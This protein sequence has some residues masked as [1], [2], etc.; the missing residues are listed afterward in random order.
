M[1]ETNNEYTL[2][3]GNNGTY[4]GT[5]YPTLEEC[6]E[7]ARYFEPFGELKPYIEQDEEIVV[8]KKNFQKMYDEYFSNK[9]VSNVIEQSEPIEESV[10][11]GEPTTTFEDI[12][13]ANEE[14]SFNEVPTTESEKDELILESL[15]VQEV[16]ESGWFL[17]DGW[18]ASHPDKVLGIPYEST[19]RYGK[20]TKYK[21]TIEDIDRIDVIVPTLSKT[22]DNSPLQ[23]GESESF[24]QS[25]SITN[26]ENQT[27]ILDEIDESNKNV[28][29]KFANKKEKS[30]NVEDDSLVFNEPELQTFEDVWRTYNQGI[31]K[32][33]LEVYIWH[34]T[35]IG[36][37]L[38][39]RWINL[40]HNKLYD[41]DLT[42][43]ERYNVDEEDINE[44]VKKGLLYYYEG[45]L[46]PAVEYLSGDMYDKKHQLDRDR[47][48]IIEKY[49]EDVYNNQSVAFNN[50]WK[51]VYDNRL[52]IGQTDESLVVLPISRL[53]SEFKIN[54]LASFAEDSEGFKIRMVTAKSDKNFG[55]PDWNKDL[56]TPDYKK[57][58]IESISLLDAFNYFLLK[59]RPALLLPVTHLDIVNYY[60]LGKSINIGSNSDDEKTKKENEAKKAK[61]KSSTQSEGERLF[62]L[63]LDT[64]LEDNDK[65]R[66]E[67]QWNSD[68]NNY[69]PIDLNKIPV[70]FN[71]C[72]KYKG[73]YEELK[74]EKREAVAFSMHTGSGILA[75]GVGVGKG[76]LLTSNICTPKGF[77]KMGDIKLGDEVIGQ[78]GL[79]TKV[80]GVYPLGKI[81]S[82]KVTFTDGS[83]TEVSEDH[84]WSVRNISD[85]SHGYHAYR[86]VETKDII[87]KLYNYR[88]NYQY[89]IPMVQPVEFEEKE[90]PLHPYILGCLLGDGGL[91]KD[92]I[93]LHNPESDIQQK[94]RALLPESVQLNVA[95][96][97]ITCRLSRVA[98]SGTNDVLNII[99]DLGLYG[100]HSNDKFIPEIYKINSS[101]N[102]IELLRGLLDTDGY[103]QLNKEG[104]KGC[105]LEYTT[106]S[107]QL[108][109]DIVFLVQS[110]GGTCTVREKYPKYT[111]NGEN[112]TG[113]LAYTIRIRL[114]KGIMPV[115]SLKHT[116]KFVEKTKYQPVRFIK[117]IEDIG[118]QEAQCIKVEAEDSLYV[119]DDFIVTHNTASAIFTMSS[120]LDSGYAKRLAV[121]VPNQVYKQFISEIKSFAPHIPVIEGYNLGNDYIPHF[122]GVDG[123]II[124]VP[125][126]SITVFTYE[127][128]EKIGFNQST[129]DELM[130]GLY[131]ILN[132][133]GESERQQ[134]DKQRAS[135]Y[136]RLETIL[137][138][139]LKGTTFTIEDFGFDFICY[140]EAHKM[141][142]AQPLD[143][144]ILTPNG[145]IKM[146]DIKIGDKVIGKDGK[147]TNVIGVYPQGKRDVYKVTFNDNSSTECCDEHIWTVRPKNTYSRTNK[148]WVDLSLKQI[149]DKDNLL[150]VKDS[151]GRNIKISTYYKHD[152]GIKR[153][154]IPIVDAVEFNNRDVLIDPYLLGCL[155]G[156]G[157][158]TKHEVSIAS[159]DQEI[160]DSISDVLPD[161]ISLK[162]GGGYSYRISQ[163]ASMKIGNAGTGVNLH[164][165]KNKIRSYLKHY[166]LFGQ[167]AWEKHIPDD[168]KFN[169]IENRI[170]LLRGLLDTD[171]FVSNKYSSIGY[172]ST[173]KQLAL[174]VVFLAQSLGGTATIIENDKSKYTYKGEQKKGRLLYRVSL[175]LPSNIIPFRLSRKAERVHT[176]IR[177]YNP[178][179]LISD[180]CHSGV[181][182][183]QCIEVDNSDGLY[184]TND[185]IVTHNCFT[186]VK[187]EMEENSAGIE[188]R[189][190]NPY[191]INS[192]TPSSIA[193]KGFMLNYYIQQ[194]NY[195]GNIMMLTA[196]P[197]TNSP[198][199]IFSMLSMVAYEKL[200][201]TNLNNIKKFF[202]T[203]VKT[204]TELVINSKLKPEF[205]PVILGFNNLI[206]L[207]SLIRRYINYKSGEEV[208]GMVRPRKYVLPYLSEMIDGVT[209]KLSNEDKIETFIPMTPLQ[210]K[211]MSGIISYVEGKG[212]L[213]AGDFSDDDE[214]ESK[215][216]SESDLDVD[217][218]VY[219]PTVSKDGNKG[220]GKGIVT[221]IITK[222]GESK[223]QVTKVSKDWEET[224]NSKVAG[225]FTESELEVYVNDGAVEVDEDMLD[226]KEKAGV[227]TIKGLSYARN[228]ALS[229]HLYVKS[230]LTKRPDYKSYIEMSPKLKYVMECIRDVKKYHESHNQPVSGQVIYMDRGVKFFPLIKEYLVKEVG[231]K[232]H[233]IGIIQS[234]LP[235]NGKRSKEYVKNLFN[236]E[237]YN[238]ITKLFEPIPDEDR[239]K[240]VIGSSTI[241]EGINLQ[242][243]GTVLYNC[244]I[245]WN[246]TD[247]QQLEGRVWRQG[248]DFGAV[249]IVNPLVIDSAD[250]FLFEKLRQKTSRLN[251]IWATEGKNNVL[252]LDEFNPEELK[253][254]L[255]RDPKVIAE[256]KSI[257]AKAQIESDILGFTRQL[258]QVD[259][260]KENAA[261]INRS[262]HDAISAAEKYRDIQLSSDKLQDAALLCKTIIEVE[263][264]Q[265]DKEGKK[266][267]YSYERNAPQQKATESWQDYSMRKKEYLDSFSS[268]NPFYK[269]YWF[270]SFALAVRDTNKMIKE[271]V[272]QYDISFSIEDFSGL[273]AF[274]D[275]VTK[276]IEDARERQ[277]YFNSDEFKKKEED[278][279]IAKRI[280]DK[281]EYKPIEESVKDFAK[282]DYLL[283]QKKSGGKNKA[284]YTSCP[285]VDDKGVRLIDDS[286]LAY[287][288]ECIE[289]EGQTK[290]L[291][292]NEDTKTYEIERQAFHDKIIKDIFTGVKCV[293]Q[294]KPIAVFTGGSPASGKSHFIK[295][296]ADYLTNESIFHLDADEIRA[297]LP[298]YKG[299]N[300]SATHKETQDIVNSILNNIGEGKCRYDFIY[301]GTMNK[302]EKYYPL[303]KKVNELGY[304]TY[305]IFMD[306]PYGVARS[307]ALAR[308]QKSGRYVPI[309]VIDDFFAPR[310]NSGG[311]T[312]GQYALDELKP[313]VNGYIVVDGIT[314][315]IIENGGEDFPHERLYDSKPLLDIEA[316]II[317]KIDEPVIEATVADAVES[318]EDLKEVESEIGGLSDRA[319]WYLDNSLNEYNNASDSRKKEMIEIVK[320]NIESDIRGKATIGMGLDED[321]VAAGEEFLKRTQNNA[322]ENQ[323]EETIEE[324]PKVTKE[325][326]ERAIKGLEVLA[327]FGDENAKKAIKGLKVLLMTFKEGG[328]IEGGYSGNSDKAIPVKAGSVI[329]TRGAIV[330]DNTKHEYEGEML[331]N[332]EVLS[333]INKEGGGVA[334][335]KGGEVKKKVLLAPNGKPTNLTPEQYKLTRSPE[336]FAWFGDFIN[337]PENASKVVDENGDPIVVYYG[338]SFE[339]FYIFDNR[340]L[341]PCN[342]GGYYFSNEK[343]LAQKFGKKIKEFFLNIQNPLYDFFD[344]NGAY[345][346]PSE[347]RDGG[348]FTK[349]NTDKYAKKG[350]KEYIVFEPTQ[351]KL[352]DGTNTTFDH[353]NPD[354]RFEDGGKLDKFKYNTNFYGIDVF[355]NV[356]MKYKDEIWSPFEK[357]GSSLP[358]VRRMDFDA[359]AWNSPILIEKYNI[360]E[361][362]DNGKEVAK[363]LISKGVD[364][365]E[366][367][368]KG[369]EYE[370]RPLAKMAKGGSLESYEKELEEQDKEQMESQFGKNNI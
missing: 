56:D 329:I 362:I 101:E 341:N 2:W 86:N 270:S 324:Q 319:K 7:N 146:G 84:I 368:K 63:F 80:L 180:I 186:S 273:N 25:T 190:R 228:L 209:T 111:H 52:T 109:D 47:D 114:P 253:Y 272:N 174:D 140:D 301:D 116:A 155:I 259:K 12:V 105:G 100:T 138:K 254:A 198:L 271:L 27:F 316:P 258:E 81:Q 73:K 178:S 34:K 197:F 29:K 215:G 359:I 224:D 225:I 153:L 239:I 147:P 17:N 212:E 207:Q 94:V 300:A 152:N 159:N 317:E 55:K 103:I 129:Q 149:M 194:K 355:T 208:V 71:M 83:F 240:I 260:L 154:Y 369:F 294:G 313:L 352:A 160:L 176:K 44:W 322:E 50:A 13:E 188:K 134:T 315:D 41:E 37:P 218:L 343:Y 262:F 365:L 249:R 261:T 309:E 42:R 221:D 205:K 331:N 328:E 213:T 125:E 141:K 285:P 179:R 59:S 85:R 247:I 57:D 106:V 200:K 102:R 122:Q 76:N 26:P 325:N 74:P 89:S 367:Y 132:Q 206:S 163:D 166:G 93:I 117:S 162:K 370:L 40:V 195:G 348:I 23:S 337:D 280:A 361:G 336:F 321:I 187:G 265:K 91:S 231:Y 69:K 350:T 289:R 318:V 196:T 77:K 65:I 306:I 268:L 172:A 24:V 113:K 334:F 173:S 339:D 4:S 45:K 283:S 112:R 338:S 192:G 19:G 31:S 130:G 142:K 233:E 98:K 311:K 277:K 281:I 49:G 170:E 92:S 354:I 255:I 70:A 323:I 20:V 214:D 284:I 226:E 263:K 66:L 123:N 126:G 242:R 75:Y 96:D 185:F 349:R 182:E 151:I 143:S 257:E 307:R 97:G 168:Y 290:D 127:G 279:V 312:M 169:S 248:N 135:F 90:L 360:S 6:F 167:K 219:Y 288:T 156:D 241:K 144:L 264:T 333:R 58:K 78:N 203:Y 139:G 278:E 210:E 199:E 18:F 30:A 291:Y 121:V 21:G 220:F 104:K 9:K 314:G 10:I 36:R 298:E 22:L 177:M 299:W 351:I 99:K 217:S 148:R 15:P 366:L 326:I 363:K 330:D 161:G 28:G 43:P 346:S 150:D 223:Y 33:E 128:I 216:G 175:V 344:F 347:Y 327:K 274:K 340:L 51:G 119:C 320:G 293:S 251:T 275:N 232:E 335:E 118:L 202:D 16:D 201:D 245:D 48:E 79:P 131:E 165:H 137:G 11:V 364:S 310:P 230:G 133:V 136:E 353:N 252:N 5:S 72:R 38:S 67:T 8:S 250:I 87:D 204:S 286:A 357:N 64:E 164:N 3:L 256:L 246:P 53:A 238:E 107:K 342:S 287:L 184:V 158:F 54:R 120:Y 237:I 243:F 332:R 60:C 222:D 46:V 267:A 115:S 266:M 61:L 295:E 229:P 303:I 88:G 227:R 236:G 39:R 292:F 95:V 345:M 183:T 1:A 244:F 14:V 68:Y 276:N 305:I 181:K 234:G 189:G 308:Y 157:T 171:G 302:A 124:N 296:V 358:A 110:F 356:E 35:Q 82:Y 145:W 211:L 32:E 235:K 297:K 304:D 269:P 62:K 191:E 108:C 193:L 282:L